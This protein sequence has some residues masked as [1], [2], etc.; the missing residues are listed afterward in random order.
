ME[1]PKPQPIT[2]TRGMSVVDRTDTL[3][4]AL[5]KLCHSAIPRSGISRANRDGEYE[6]Y[7]DIHY[8]IRD[9]LEDMRDNINESSDD[10]RNFPTILDT[11]VGGRQNISYALSNKLHKLYNDRFED[12]DYEDIQRTCTGEIYHESIGTIPVELCDIYSPDN[13]LVLLAFEAMQK[14]HI[15][16]YSGRR[17]EL[18]INVE[19]MPDEMIPVIVRDT[20]TG[21]EYHGAV[22]CNSNVE[23]C[24][25][26]LS[27]YKDDCWGMFREG[28]HSWGAREDFYSE[29]SSL[30]MVF[31]LFI[32]NIDA[33][34]SDKIQEVN[35]IKCYFHSKKKKLCCTIER[36]NTNFE[37][38][39]VG[40]MSTHEFLP[41][42]FHS[43]VLVESLN[44]RMETME[45]YSIFPASKYFEQ[46]KYF[47]KKDIKN[48]MHL[49]EEIRELTRTMKKYQNARERCI[50]N[51]IILICM[52]L[53][54]FDIRVPTEIWIKILSFPKIGFVI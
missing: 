13:N 38:S 8:E 46:V 31:T 4:E 34:Y 53:K 32:G 30:K 21:E 45:K 18:A 33:Y 47:R 28:Q 5:D 16:S 10:Y 2:G 51:K 12:Y 19:M 24:Y 20:R 6:S 1:T 54:R 36:E 40:S 9:V 43:R 49:S 17:F 27:S 11:P 26:S 42:D 48:S 29:C 23:G 37:V 14:L 3:L 35:R 41:G 22:K 44:C 52:C 15:N 39:Y 50:K 25:S 7:H